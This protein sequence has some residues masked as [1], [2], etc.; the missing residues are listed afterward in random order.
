MLVFGSLSLALV[1]V[2]LF[3]LN[4]A[5]YYT[6]PHDPHTV[7]AGFRELQA[8]PDWF[9]VQEDEFPL[10]RNVVGR[11]D[12]RGVWG[13]AIRLRQYQDF[14]DRVPEDV[15]WRLLGV[16]YVVTWRGSLVTQRGRDIQ[17][18][19]MLGQEGEGES[20]KHFYQLPWEP[21]RAF[22]VREVFVARDR[23][24][25]Y[26]ILGTD[27][28]DPHQTAVLWQ[29]VSLRPATEAEDQVHIAVD[30]PSHIELRVDL[31]AP[32]LLVLGE[33]TYPGW[34]V[35]VNGTRDT[36][37]EADGV[38]R[39]VQL[40]EGV[41]T[42]VFRFMPLTFYAGMAISSLTVLLVVANSVLGWRRRS[43]QGECREDASGLLAATR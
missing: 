36:L 11:R 43:R 7:S 42:V 21:R 17:D 40:P 2:D 32:G 27:G 8:D 9:R 20:L 1:I 14:L 35:Y 37:H 31:G 22:V 29:P 41:S 28:F 6:K 23:E 18:A 24:H 16:R 15:R 5:R 13:V 19:V 26:Q 25:L 4:R 34:R 30:T 33:V 12:L 3:T 39:S 38:L 10:V